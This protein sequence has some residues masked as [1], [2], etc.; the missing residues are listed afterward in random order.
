[1]TYTN[2][3][4]ALLGVQKI[5]INL[6][7]SSAGARKFRLETFMVLMFKKEKACM[8]STI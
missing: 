5:V 8:I 1:M 2:H 7:T 4:T 6:A 3:V